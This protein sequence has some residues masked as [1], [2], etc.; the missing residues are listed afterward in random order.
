MRIVTLLF[1]VVSA[2]AQ[3]SSVGVGEVSI[4]P[5][6]AEVSITIREVAPD[7][8]NASKMSS[9]KANEIVP[10]LK[11]VGGKDIKTTSISLNPQYNYDGG[12]QKQVGFE[13]VYSLVV[14]TSLDKVGDLIDGAIGKGANGISGLSFTATKEVLA[15]AKSEA[16]KR[17]TENA[18]SQ[19]D[20]ALGGIGK[21]RGE[22]TSVKVL[23]EWV[24]SPRPMMMEAMAV[25]G[26]SA[27]PIEGG[28]LS[29]SASVEVTVGL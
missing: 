20:S 29:V 26:A 16:I 11:S 6:E 1:F 23:S 18:L 27:A 19:I 10:W 12:K 28:S 5:T 14:T 13:S 3:V 9:K 22:V 17:A 2:F 25:R 21:S 15:K 24:P 8:A 7:A 4:E